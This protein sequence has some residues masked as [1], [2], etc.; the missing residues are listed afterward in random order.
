VEPFD[1]K[2]TIKSVNLPL[3]HIARFKLEKADG[4]VRLMIE[5]IP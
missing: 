4:R 3:V 1:E 2:E 5:T